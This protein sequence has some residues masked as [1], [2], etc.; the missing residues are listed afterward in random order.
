MT[1]LPT[2]EVSV[3]KCLGALNEPY[4]YNVKPQNN[5]YVSNSF[6]ISF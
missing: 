5:S 2:Y 6:I 1:V 4:Y 3:T